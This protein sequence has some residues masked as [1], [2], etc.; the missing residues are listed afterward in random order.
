MPFSAR[1]TGW[2]VVHD[3]AGFLNCDANHHHLV[4]VG[5]AR[6]STVELLVFPFFLY[7]LAVPHGLW[8]LSSPTRD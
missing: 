2:G 4:K 6:F 1:T 3:T 5:P 7:F 8:D